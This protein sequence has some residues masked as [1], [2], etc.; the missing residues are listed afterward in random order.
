MIRVEP[1]EIQDVLANPGMGW[2][3]FHRF[4][5]E[6]PNLHGIPTGAAYLRFGWKELEPEE[7]RIDFAQFDGLLAHAR[8][9]GQKLGFRVMIAASGGS[10][11]APEWL[12]AKGVAGWE[13][14]SEGRDRVWAPDLADPVVK[15]A[16]ARLLRELGARYDGHHDLDYIDMG[17]VGLWGEWHMSGT[18]Q[19]ENKREVPLPSPARRQEIIDEYITSFPKTPKLML[20]GDVDGMKHA[21]GRH[22]G[23]RADCLGDMGGF[24]CTWNHMENLYKPRIEETGAGEAWQH[25]PVAWESCWDMRKWVEEGWDV[26]F[27]LNYGLELH[28]SYLN[29]K[30]APITEA[31]RPEIDRFLR[32]LGYRFVLRSVEHPATA[33][34]GQAVTVKMAWANVGVAPP[35]H[36]YRLGLRLAGPQGKRVLATTGTSL[37]GWLPGERAVTAELAIPADLPKGEYELSVGVVHPETHVAE[38]RLAITGRDEAGWYPVSKLRVG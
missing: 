16:H 25:A 18:Q 11:Y 26:P 22:C 2:Q 23:W 36:D 17:S 10:G 20:I 3:T 35:Y 15:H 27:I 14:T 37:R 1:V 24:S 34:A 30:S 8:K 19:V 33:A 7:G 32:K 4:A 6:D 12:R 13:Y 21:V 5:D 38:V 31:M 28:G 9:A 29:N